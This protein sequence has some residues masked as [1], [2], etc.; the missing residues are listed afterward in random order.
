MVDIS[1]KDRGQMR[2]PEVRAKACGQYV[3][4]SSDYDPLAVVRHLLANLPG[5]Y[6]GGDSLGLALSTRLHAILSISACTKLIV[7]VSRSPCVCTIQGL[8][9]E[10]ASKRTLEGSLLRKSLGKIRV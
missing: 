1:T 9:S 2:S 10:S 3:R 6:C 7:N 8:L 4:P 5:V